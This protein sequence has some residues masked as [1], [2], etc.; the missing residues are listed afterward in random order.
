MSL[1]LN[2]I[3]NKLA[4]KLD[5]A[6]INETTE[7]LTK[8]LTNKRMSNNTKSSIEYYVVKSIDILGDEINNKIITV[9]RNELLARLEK[10]CIAKHK[11]EVKKAYWAGIDDQL[12]P[13]K[14]PNSEE[15]YIKTFGGEQ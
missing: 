12:N 5:E 4:N 15:Y 14:M 7:T 3:A 6:L 8:F 10:Q 13:N 11:E 1:D 2:K 9:E